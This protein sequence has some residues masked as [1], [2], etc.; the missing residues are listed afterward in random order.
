MH[1]LYVDQPSAWQLQEIKGDAVVDGERHV[2]VD[3]VGGDADLERGPLKGKVAI[4]RIKNSQYLYIAFSYLPL[5]LLPGWRPDEKRG[6]ESLFIGILLLKCP[7]LAHHRVP[8][9]V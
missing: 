1:V 3:L 8:D 5:G 6:G 7:L 4:S 9:A 2:V